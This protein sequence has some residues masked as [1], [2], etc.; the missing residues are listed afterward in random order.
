MIS[1][2]L[3]SKNSFPRNINEV[4]EGEVV[5]EKAMKNTVYPSDG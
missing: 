2:R 4:H 5:N 3:E 1:N